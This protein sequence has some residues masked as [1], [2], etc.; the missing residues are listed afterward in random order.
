MCIVLT[1]FQAN[2][3]D[4]FWYLKSL[5]VFNFWQA[6]PCKSGSLLS[7]KR[8]PFQQSRYDLADRRSHN[9]RRSHYLVVLMQ[10][11]M[12]ILWFHWSEKEGVNATGHQNQQ[13]AVWVYNVFILYIHI[14]VSWRP[15]LFHLVILRICGGLQSQAAVHCSPFRVL[16]EHFH[17]LLTWTPNKCHASHAS[18]VRVWW[19]LVTWAGRTFE[20]RPALTLHILIWAVE[21]HMLRLRSHFKKLPFFHAKTCFKYIIIKS[22][23]PQNFDALIRWMFLFTIQTRWVS[24]GVTMALEQGRL[25]GHVARVDQTLPFIQYGTNVKSRSWQINRWEKE[26]SICLTR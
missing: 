3:F 2:S 14:K 4:V 26:S 13:K 15:E 9:P 5:S 8:R 22:L 21:L 16:H 1:L 23:K 7:M 17:L 18:H 6:H 10:T 20:V 24:L 19:G 12:Q 25:Q 11:S